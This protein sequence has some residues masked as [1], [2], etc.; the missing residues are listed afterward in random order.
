MPSKR[1]ASRRYRFLKFVVVVAVLAIVALIIVP[2]GVS[3][4]RDQLSTWK[5]DSPSYKARGGHWSTL[6]LPSKFRVNAIHAVLLRA[7]KVLI[8]AGSGNDLGNF[9][10]RRFQSLLWD[11]A[12]DNYK[13]VPTPSDMFCGGHAVLPDGKVLIAGGTQRYE[14]LASAVTRAAGVV[15]VKNENPDL[16][17]ILLPEGTD[18]VSPNGIVFR[19]TSSTLVG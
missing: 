10:A 7:G 8:V 11:P 3:Y 2:L 16:G 15:T 19:S 14:V 17:P 1:R 4:A 18:F 6:V 9:A 12:T 13:L 5:L